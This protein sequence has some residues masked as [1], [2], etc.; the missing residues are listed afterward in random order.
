MGNHGG[1]PPYPL[2]YFKDG[3]AGK[4]GSRSGQKMTEHLPA[5]KLISSGVCGISK[6]RRPINRVSP[7]AEARKASTACASMCRLTN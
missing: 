5:G 1:K 4:D 3:I 7:S 6:F 2:T